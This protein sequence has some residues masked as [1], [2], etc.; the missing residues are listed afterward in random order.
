[1][2]RQ[3]EVGLGCTPSLFDVEASSQG[4]MGTQSVQTGVGSGQPRTERVFLSLS[5]QLYFSDSLSLVE[6]L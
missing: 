5:H 2:H 4:R 3:E 1:M 6:Y